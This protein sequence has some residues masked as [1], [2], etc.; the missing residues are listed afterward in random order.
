MKTII[1]VNV[2]TPESPEPDDIGVYLTEFLMDG[3]IMTVPRPFRDLLVKAFIIPKRKFSSSEKYK[4][5][6]TPE[7]SPL[8]VY[9]QALKNRLQSFLGADWKVVIAMQVGKP[10][11]KKVLQENQD[12]E[13]YFCPLYPQFAKATTG[14]A[15]QSLKSIRKP[16]KI[17]KPFY[18]ESWFIQSVSRKIREKLRPED[19]LLLSYHGLPISQLSQHR[20]ACE[21]SVDCCLDISACAQDCYKAQCLA[22]TKLLEKELGFSKITTSFQSRLGRDR[23][24]EPSTEE[25]ALKLA[26]VGVKNLKVACPSF[27]ADCLETL[28]EIGLDLKEQ[29][30][31]AGGK[32]FELIPC[33]NDDALFVEGL[34]RHISIFS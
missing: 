32:S 9:S 6:W 14:G 27:V 5:I 26:A 22:T 33:V 23:W 12:S 2:G 4:R 16:I 30:L 13:I 21:R 8:M 20:G 24:I 17:L 29:F 25:T 11:L 15:L 18:H 19:H 28:E 10:S 3:N 7:G 31:A 1:L 34:G